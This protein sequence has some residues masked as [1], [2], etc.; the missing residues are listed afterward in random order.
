MNCDNFMLASETGGFVRRWQARRHAA[1]CPR[2]AAVRAAFA[3]TKRRLATPEPLSHDVRQ[4]WKR[5]A[6]KA[7]A[8][9]ARRQ[10][11][12]AVA[13]G[14]V[15]AVSLLLV[16]LVIS[17]HDHSP[18]PP[19][20]PT[21]AGNESRSLSP[22]TVEEID[23][24]RG[25]VYLSGE[26]QRLDVELKTLRERIEKDKVQRQIA[27]TLENFGGPRRPSQNRGVP[28]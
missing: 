4:S 28:Q 24:S 16:F 2:C 1:R 5:A 26:V 13:V 8:R 15:V 17:R 22:I 7:T 18:T 12:K 14:A 20:Q 19:S 10:A 21:V 9:P 27:A 25:L 23:P 6:D 3:E 11:W